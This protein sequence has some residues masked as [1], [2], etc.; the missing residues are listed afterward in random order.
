MFILLS[1]S[2]SLSLP[3]TFSLF[4]GAYIIPNSIY[5]TRMRVLRRKY[6]F[7]NIKYDCV[8]LCVVILWVHI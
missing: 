7:L 3:L 2:L 8:W 6:V 4:L 5:V 1:F